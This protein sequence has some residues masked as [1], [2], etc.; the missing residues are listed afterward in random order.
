MIELSLEVNMTDMEELYGIINSMGGAV[1]KDVL[2]NTSA[3]FY[4]AGKYTAN[5]WNNYL[6]GSGNLDGLEPLEKPIPPKDAKLEVL[7]KGDFNVTV[8]SDSERLKKL[9]EGEPE[10]EYDMKKTHP[11]GRKSRVSSKGIPYLIIPFRWGSPNGKDTKR[12]WNN[13]IPQA[14]YNTSVKHLR[15]SSKIHKF[16]I[17]LNARG[18]EIQRQDYDWA[19]KNGRLTEDQAWHP[20][21]IGMVRMKDVKGSTY[22]TFRIISATSPENSWIYHRDSKP[23]VDMLSALQRTV[24]KNVQNIVDSGL[25]ADLGIE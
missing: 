21:A 7:R 12:R 9:Q 13:F 16:H 10:V 2:P 24:E 11:Y 1:N 15:I 20:N 25:R 5:I 4:E 17:E 14:S 18:E 3:A 6:A 19:R 22:F 23:P 8:G